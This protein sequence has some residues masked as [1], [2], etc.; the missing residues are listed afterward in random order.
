MPDGFGQGIVPLLKNPDLDRTDSSSNY[1]GIT[2]S[3]VI[4]K[5]FEMVVKSL[6]EEQLNSDS[7]Q[8]GFKKQSS[9]SHAL[10]TVR[11]TAEHYVKNGCTVSI[12]ALDLS[13]AFDKV[14]HFGLL[15]LLMKRHFT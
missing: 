15:Q 6:Y 7:L 5:L 13:K 10:F 9:C 4:S 8:F 11:T 2:L 1:R 14:D 3:T 12:C